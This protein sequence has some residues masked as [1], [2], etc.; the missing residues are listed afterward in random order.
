MALYS[1]DWYERGAEYRATLEE[2][3]YLPRD[4]WDR[5]HEIETEDGSRLSHVW[6]ALRRDHLNIC[7]PHLFTERTLTELSAVSNRSWD[8][9]E[10]QAR[11]VRHLRDKVEGE[12]DTDGGGSKL[13]S[14]ASYLETIP[15]GEFQAETLELWQLVEWTERRHDGFF[16]E[17]QFLKR[18]IHIL[19]SNTEE[20]LQKHVGDDGSIP[21][22]EFHDVR[23][24]VFSRLPS[25]SERYRRYPIEKPKGGRR[26]IEE[27]CEGLKQ[28][29]SFI[30]RILSDYR[31][32][33]PCATGFIENRS[34]ALH[35]RYHAGARAAIVVD[36]RD[37]FPS[38]TR[39]QVLEALGFGPKLMGTTDGW[40]NPFANWTRN[41][42]E[43]LADLVLHPYN[44][45]LPQGAPSSPPMANL[46][47]VKLDKKVRE[48]VSEQFE[49]PRFWNYSRYAD[50][51]VLSTRQDCSEQE[52]QE[53]YLILLDA[54][55]SMG[56]RPAP[57]KTKRWRAWEEG[58]L[59]ICG[60][61]VP[62]ERGGELRLPRSQRRRVR[63]A[64]HH[65]QTDDADDRDRG[66][67][68]YAYTVTGNYAYRVRSASEPAS[69]L[70]KLASGLASTDYER[71]KILD[72]WFQK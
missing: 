71:K 52:L 12:S 23:H 37:F 66:L 25:A 44:D 40:A 8:A 24:T 34:T 9:T 2:G 61:E 16:P 60:I 17:A 13:A 59:T 62:R 63:S 39:S 68:A 7:W 47:A 58:P 56:W 69:L 72:G 45:R 11:L 36:I 42:H 41:A 30:S 50:D 15:S 32:A 35:A 21:S 67:L 53:A 5:L 38:I 3:R 51:M 43:M 10:L 64:V 29:Q 4:E 55:R 28:V 27:P 20:T 6:S 46:V 54:I 33:H 70:S 1:S 22:S 14:Y 31:A 26:W 19:D 18:A 65:Y 49:E 57:E 48:L